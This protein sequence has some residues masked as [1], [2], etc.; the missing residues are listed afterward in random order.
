MAL[1]S[2]AL[3]M[4]LMMALV[5]A[6]AETQSFGV[7]IASVQQESPAHAAVPRKLQA[8]AQCA[9]V[10][11][12]LPKQPV[13]GTDKKQYDSACYAGCFSKK[14]AYFGPCSAK[15]CLCAP[16]F[17]PV[18][19][20]GKTYINSCF[21]TCQG[22]KSSSPGVC[23]ADCGCPSTN[24]PVCGYDG[25]AYTNECKA[26]CAG[27][28]PYYSGTCDKRVG[29]CVCSNTIDPVCVTKVLETKIPGTTQ[30]IKTPYNETY[31]NPCLAACDGADPKATKKGLCSDFPLWNYQG[32]WCNCPTTFKPVCAQGPLGTNMTLNSECT[33]KCLG[34]KV[35]NQGIC[36][37][38]LCPSTAKPVC[39]GKKTYRTACDAR[40]KGKATTWTDGP[41]T[42]CSKCPAPNPM[43]PIADYVCGDNGQ[44]YP[45]SC[46]AECEGVS[47]KSKG[48]CGVPNLGK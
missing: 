36:T 41:C 48:F 40:C 12:T 17:A 3:A 33:A 13:C 35:L 30:V 19:G 26:F 39:V 9:A 23:G 32:W 28:Q 37:N 25:K 20:G 22:V 4:G 7:S 42:P 21:A 11:A 24:W 6:H 16:F 44:S 29:P 8:G 15:P 47:V 10:C 43:N 2:A 34:Y 14:I 1:K 18:C 45:S 27:A 31:Q 38:C 5:S 46:L